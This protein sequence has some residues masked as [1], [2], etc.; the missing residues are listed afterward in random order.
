MRKVTSIAF[1]AVFILRVVLA[2]RCLV[3]V[4]QLLP[5]GLGLILHLLLAVLGL[6][7]SGCWAV[8]LP[9]ELPVLRILH[10]HRQ[11]RSQ[12]NR[13]LFVWPEIVHF[14]AENRE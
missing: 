11:N 10:K 14:S 12:V 2:E 5:A 6:L 13:V 9:I 8:P 1:H 4:V 3:E 7:L